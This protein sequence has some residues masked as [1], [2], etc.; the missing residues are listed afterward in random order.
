MQYCLNK[1]P[2]SGVDIWYT[3]ESEWVDMQFFNKGKWKPLNIP[4]A[5]SY[6]L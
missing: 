1:T 6:V 5:L 2:I 3:V 4:H